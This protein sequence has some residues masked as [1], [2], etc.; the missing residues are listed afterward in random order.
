MPADQ[1]LLAQMKGTTTRAI[2]QGLGV[3]ILYDMHRSGLCLVVCCTVTNDSSLMIKENLMEGC[4][5]RFVAHNAFFH[6]MQFNCGKLFIEQILKMNI[7][8]FH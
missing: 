8:N 4:A 6:R 3:C 7:S 2:S 1:L 5:C